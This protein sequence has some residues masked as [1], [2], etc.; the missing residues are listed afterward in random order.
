MELAGILKGKKTYIAAGISIIAAI[1]GYLTGDA[2][3]M[4]AI[5]LIGTAFMAAGLKHGQANPN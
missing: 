2:T 4:Q 1:A 3:G 5:Q